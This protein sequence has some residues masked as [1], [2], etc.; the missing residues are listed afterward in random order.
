MYTSVCLCLCLSVCLSVYVL[1]T[2]AYTVRGTSEGTCDFV[3]PAHCTHECILH[4]SCAAAGECACSAHSAD[5]FTVAFCDTRG[6]KTAMRPFVS[7]TVH[8][9]KSRQKE[10]VVAVDGFSV[11][12]SVDA[13]QVPDL[14]RVVTADRQSVC[15]TDDRR[16]RWSRE[17]STTHR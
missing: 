10:T 3:T 7:T 13:D 15:I 2:R 5:E 1:G 16:V 8:V 4:C 17:V 11:P 12:A 9:N 14:F 6:D